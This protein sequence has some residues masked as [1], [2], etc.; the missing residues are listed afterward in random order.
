MKHIS[1][2][3]LRIPQQWKL[4]TLYQA[5]CMPCHGA[6]GE[7]GIGPNLT[8]A[9]WIHGSTHLSM[10]EIVTDGVLEKGMTP[11]GSI[12][13]V[14]ERAQ[15]VAFVASLQGTNPPNAKAPQ[16]ELTES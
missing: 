8:D 9:Y 7:G 3:F 6:A 13:S 12:L 1:S 2:P 10:F 4:A 5:N 14:E 15:I 11:W 16:G